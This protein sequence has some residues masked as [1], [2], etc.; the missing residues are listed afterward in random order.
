MVCL[1]ADSSERDCNFLIPAGI[2]NLL[3]QKGLYQ[4]HF[5][6]PDFQIG[7]NHTKNKHKLRFSGLEKLVL[8]VVFLI[9]IIFSIK[10]LLL[11]TIASA[12]ESLSLP[13][14]K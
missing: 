9:L 14:D 7:P 6:S 1:L 4:T 13:L 10:N 12:F 3:I 8:G 5:A 11:T 2:V